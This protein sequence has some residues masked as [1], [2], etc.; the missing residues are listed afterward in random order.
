M[1]R[2]YYTGPDVT[3]ALNIEELRQRAHKYLPGFALEY[4]EGGAEDEWS[5]AWNQE[6]FKTLR[7]RPRYLVDTG[8]RS[9]RTTL[10]GVERPTPLIVAPTGHNGLI[11]RNGDT[12]LARAA[13]AMNIP[14][15]LSTLSNTR[16]ERLAKNVSGPL[17]MQLYVFKDFDL[18]RDILKRADEAGYEALVFTIDTNIHGW[19]EWDRRQFRAPGQLT[20]RGALE[21]LR[22]PQWL[23]DVMIPHGAPRLENVVD[24]FPP[25]A[26]DTRGAFVHV[27]GLFTP[28]ITWKSVE[29][30]R[31]LWPRK[32][33]LKGVLSVDDAQLAADHGCDGIVVSNHGAR[34]MDSCISPMQVL[35]E[36]VATV[37]NRMTVI[38][39]GGFRRGADV[40][41]AI[42]LGA[43]AVMVGRAAL[44]G[45]GAGG[46]AGVCQALTLLQ[47]EIH[48]ALGQL[49]CNS[50]SELGPEYLMPDRIRMPAQ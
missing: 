14:Y 31:E 7:F 10:F 21:A 13:G 5:L 24:F 49:G 16:L 6:I 33:L 27:P 22:H 28:T 39:D 43:D 4:L 48:R 45:L 29:S 26:R 40:V 32:L 17:W 8:A 41:K 11:R 37:G 23:L 44:Y 1:K 25:D 36:I 34:H 3:K 35:P 30:L 9:I 38:I 47:N 15:T 20:R 46:E 50:L 19:R 18:T 42:A 2:R 12:L